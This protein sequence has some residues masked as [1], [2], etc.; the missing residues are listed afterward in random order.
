MPV[1]AAAGILVVV[2]VAGAAAVLGRKLVAIQT[3]AYVCSWGGASA[4]CS[5]PCGD[6]LTELMSPGGRKRLTLRMPD[7]VSETAA[8]LSA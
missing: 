6:L 8:G 2:F 4:C 7:Q 1:V 5:E 3:E